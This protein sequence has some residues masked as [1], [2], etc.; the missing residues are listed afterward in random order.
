MVI[1]V[2]SARGYDPQAMLANEDPR[3]HPRPGLEAEVWVEP[4]AE[5]WFW[6]RHFGAWFAPSPAEERGFAR[7]FGRFFVVPSTNVTNFSL[8][9]QSYLNDIFHLTRVARVTHFVCMPLITGLFLVAL[10]PLHVGLVRG[11]MLGAVVLAAWWFTWGLRE[12]LVLWG[13]V[14]AAWAG[15]IFAGAQWFASTQ[16]SPW[17]PLAVLAFLQAAS[18]GPEPK[19]PPRV[20]GSPRWMSFREYLRAE[21]GGPLPPRT[22][23]LR[24]LSIVET[25][26]Y[27]TIDEA[28]ASPRL[29]PIQ[30]LEILWLLGYAKETRAAWKSLSARA[31]ASGQPAIDFIGVGGGATLKAPGR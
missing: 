28:I 31:A 11:D 26:V 16:A 23:A 10:R 9:Y 12:R 20:T 4:S 5:Q 18:H 14:A 6:V 17:L 30:L 15:A 8:Q 19:L 27:G 1:A 13:V 24:L 22:I 7:W 29:A 25:A 2:Q 3:V 21:D